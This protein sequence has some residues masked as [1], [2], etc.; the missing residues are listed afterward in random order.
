MWNM[1][2]GYLAGLVLWHALDRKILGTGTD[3]ASSSG[4][5]NREAQTRAAP[6]E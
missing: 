6:R 2:A 3:E 1:G 4:N 5:A